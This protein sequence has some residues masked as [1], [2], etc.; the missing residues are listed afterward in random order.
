V[1]AVSLMSKLPVPTPLVFK[2][3][4][5]IRDAAEAFWG[6]GWKLHDLKVRDPGLHARL[7]SA[8]SRMDM[9]CPR[10]KANEIELVAAAR[11]LVVMW[12][13]AAAAM[14]AQKPET[15]TAPTPGARMRR[16]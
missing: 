4:V 10:E 15:E 9:A 13:E 16:Q 7:L 5:A 1:L 12:K 8:I 11:A 2:C 14:P 3:R 6:A